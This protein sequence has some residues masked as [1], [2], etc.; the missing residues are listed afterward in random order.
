MHPGEHHGASSGRVEDSGSWNQ[1]FFW[2]PTLLWVK[3]CP[4]DVGW[5]SKA[6]RTAAASTASSLLSPSSDPVGQDHRDRLAEEKG[7]YG[8]LGLASHRRGWEYARATS[9]LPP[10]RFTEPE[11]CSGSRWLKAL[12]KHRCHIC[13][14]PG[15][16]TFV[17]KIDPQG[18]LGGSV[19]EH[20]P[21]AQVVIL[22]S[23]G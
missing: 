10:S 18:P 19:V 16:Q 6:T 14:S 23:L 22:E 13:F 2:K 5:N 11:F 17:F 20:L 9:R 3:H 7:G 1:L 12:G 8:A 4:W 15:L 21:S